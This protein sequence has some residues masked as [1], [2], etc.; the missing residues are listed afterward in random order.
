MCVCARARA[1]ACA[2]AGV[3][4]ATLSHLGKAQIKPGSVTGNKFHIFRRDVFS[5]DCNIELIL[6]ETLE[7]K[8]FITSVKPT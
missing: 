2:H 4:L 1:R 6:L 3:S 8:T 7:G 5:S